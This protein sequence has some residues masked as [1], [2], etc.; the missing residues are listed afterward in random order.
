MQIQSATWRYYLH[1][2][3][4]DLLVVRHK[5]HTVCEAQCAIQGGGDNFALSQVRGVN[6]AVGNFAE[7]HG[8]SGSCPRQSPQCVLLVC[9]KFAENPEFRVGNFA[10][11]L[12]REISHA[13]LKCHETPPPPC[14]VLWPIQ[15]NE[16]KRGLR[17]RLIG[18]LERGGGYHES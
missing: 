4:I 16:K 7:P 17:A 6:F 11:N 18:K 5:A 3:K 1:V 12:K 2:V 8:L 15:K 9:E 13:K 10:V 14:T